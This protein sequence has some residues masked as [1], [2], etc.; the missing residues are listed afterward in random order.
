MNIAAGLYEMDNDKPIMTMDYM[1]AVVI[2]RD[3][4]HCSHVLMI[5]SQYSH[6]AIIEI[7]MLNKYLCAGN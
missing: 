1:A 5:Y 3:H 2:A 6:I 7:D 4:D